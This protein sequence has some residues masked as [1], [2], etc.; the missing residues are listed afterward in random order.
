MDHLERRWLFVLS[1]IALVGAAAI[2]VS[3][4]T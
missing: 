2:I 4:M 3:A 1:C